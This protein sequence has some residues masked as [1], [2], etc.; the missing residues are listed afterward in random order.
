MKRAR[1]EP[2]PRP[3]H[4]RR[5]DGTRYL[6]TH[7]SFR[8]DDWGRQL[9]LEYVE[10][11]AYVASAMAPQPAWWRRVLSALRRMARRRDD[12]APGPG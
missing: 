6:L 8:D 2:W 10:E 7:V 4:R 11:K 1:N 9:S 12:A 3:G 5:I